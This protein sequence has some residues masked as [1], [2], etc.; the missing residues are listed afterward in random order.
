MPALV[1]PD[2]PMILDLAFLEGIELCPQM[3]D[4]ANQGTNGLC[5]L[6]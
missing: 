3:P 1:D 6:A 5:V 4:F 2:A